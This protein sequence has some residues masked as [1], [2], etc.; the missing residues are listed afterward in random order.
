M[1]YAELITVITAWHLHTHQ[2]G[3]SNSI[4]KTVQLNHT[5]KCINQIT[6]TIQTGSYNLHLQNT[7]GCNYL[8]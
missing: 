1:T 5:V 6:N 3:N 4:H 8:K 2:Q 7:H